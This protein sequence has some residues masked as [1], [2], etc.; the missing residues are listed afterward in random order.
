MI[1]TV[2]IRVR[3]AEKQLAE[4]LE[5]IS[6]QCFP[7]SIQLE[8]IVVDN[9]SDDRS[10]EVAESFG[11]KVIPI[12]RN[13]FNWSKAINWGMQEARGE[14]VLIISADVSIASPTSLRLLLSECLREETIAAYG[15]QIPRSNAPIDEVVR[16]S[17]AF[18]CTPPRIEISS[19]DVRADADLPFVSNAFAIVRKEAWEELGT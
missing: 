15:R 10:R 2:L 18:P 7:M 1:L 17:K 13:E 11:A 12:S 5:L 14:F 6:Q 3:N 19:V 8:Y 9:E 4:C 16:L